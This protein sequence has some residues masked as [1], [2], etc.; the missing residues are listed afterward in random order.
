MPELASVS[1]S[2]FD[3]PRSASPGRKP[4]P[5]GTHVYLK[6]DP[7]QEGV[8]QPAKPRVVGGEVQVPVRIGGRTRWRPM[9]ALAEV[10]A[11]DGLSDQLLRGET[12]GPDWLRRRLTRSRMGGQVTNEI[13]SMGVSDTEFHAYQY[14]PVLQL[15]CSPNHALLLADEV[16]LG[17]TIEAGLVWTELRARYQYNRLLVV[18]PTTLKEKWRVELDRRFGV[19]AHVVDARELRQRLRRAGAGFA[20]I[21][22]MDALA[23]PRNSDES[24]RTHLAA[25]LDKPLLEQKPIDLLVV[26]EAHRMRNPSTQRHKLGRLLNGAAHH[27]LFL[28]ATPIHLRSRD[29]H[30]LLSLIDPDTFAQ[31]RSVDEV[32][33][34]N[35]PLIRLRELC[36]TPEGPSVSFS[37]IRGWP[38]MRA[39]RLPEAMC[40]RRSSEA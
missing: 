11:D 27:R 34:A 7:S 14:K 31:Q 9:D 10:V 4:W 29:L 37:T 21:A 26:D 5:A 40:W 2:V 22:S 30:S 18:C 12:V 24:E 39:V 6:H 16:G 20:L 32:I 15:L 35:A 1:Q 33:E 19:N 38:V 13:Y 3:P 28:S 36:R 25:D 8:V 17:K 23:P